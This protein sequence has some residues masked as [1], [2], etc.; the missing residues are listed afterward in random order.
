VDSFDAMTSKRSYTNV[1][2]T[3]AEAIIELKACMGTQ[4]DPVITEKFIEVIE[5]N[6][7]SFDDYMNK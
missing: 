4:F 3:Y 1:R 2:M 6:Q 5:L 7:G